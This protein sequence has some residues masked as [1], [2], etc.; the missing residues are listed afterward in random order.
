MDDDD[1][2]DDVLALRRSIRRV[3]TE[4]R[5]LTDENATLLAEKA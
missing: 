2:D 4:I 3:R 1:D 5:L